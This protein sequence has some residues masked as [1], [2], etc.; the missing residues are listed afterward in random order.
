[1]F[2]SSQRESITLLEHLSNELIYEIFE[3]LHFHHA[4]DAFFDL[5]ERFQNLF[6][7]SNFSIKINISSLSK[8]TFH[9][10]LTH[11]IILH[12]NRIKSLRLSN[13]FAPDISLLLFPIMTNLTRLETLIINNIE[14]D[15]N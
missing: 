5:N 13:P 11:I 7:N 1:M 12:T 2:F 3:F 4:F 10:Y 6:V 14:S 9:R 8:S 15:Y